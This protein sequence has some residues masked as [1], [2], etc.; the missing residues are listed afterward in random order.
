[1]GVEKLFSRDF[2]NEIRSQVIESSFA[3]GAENSHKL[4]LW[5]LFQQPH[6]IA[7]F[8]ELPPSD[9]KDKDRPDV[10]VCDP[11]SRLMGGEMIAPL[12]A[13]SDV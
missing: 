1:V 13:K 9:A 7:S 12:L 2:T 6:L 10:G 5:F 3:A 8:T 4:L 11:D